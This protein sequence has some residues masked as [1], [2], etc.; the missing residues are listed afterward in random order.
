[1]SCSVKTAFTPSF[2]T[3]SLRNK[4]D[5]SVFGVLGTRNNLA[6]KVRYR[7][8]SSN[9]Q[10]KTRVANLKNWVS[11]Y[12]ILLNCTRVQIYLQ[13]EKDDFSSMIWHFENCKKEEPQIRVCVS[14]L[15]TGLWVQ[16]RYGL[17]IFNDTVF[18]F[19]I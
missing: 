12:S 14:R 1:M 4:S 16:L 9:C 17:K 3:V 5:S 8:G 13:R 7:L 2:I 10:P 15:S 18:Y 6:V 11:S 19:N